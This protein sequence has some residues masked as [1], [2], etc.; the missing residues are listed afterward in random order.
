MRNGLWYLLMVGLMY[1]LVNV[2]TAEMTRVTSE[3]SG[4]LSVGGF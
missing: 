3:L 1:W 4:L 2:V